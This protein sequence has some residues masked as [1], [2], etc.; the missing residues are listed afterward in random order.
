MTL[1]D[2]VLRGVLSLLT[3][4]LQWAFLIRLGLAA[5]GSVTREKEAHTWAVLLATPLDDK[6]I[7]QGKALAALRRNLAL[8]IPLLVIY[9]LMGS[10]RP[11]GA[12]GLPSWVPW[13]GAPLVH[14][15]G[16]ALFLIGAGLY[17]GLRCRTTTAAVAWLFG[18]YLVLTLLASL[19]PAGCPNLLPPE[20]GGDVLGSPVGQLVV[21]CI[22]GGLGLFA[23][24]ESVRRLRR[25]VF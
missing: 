20:S 25:H 7:I 4:I 14:L 16:T 15:I 21:G 2:P 9:G 12:H 19:L 24:R 11:S 6:E 17:A 23:L 3:W 22:G 5:T 10:L 8:F 1:A 18:V 13:M